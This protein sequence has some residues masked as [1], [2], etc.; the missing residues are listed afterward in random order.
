M[1]PYFTFLGQTYQLFA[2]LGLLALFVASGVAY[3]RAHKMGLSYFDM[4]MGIIFLGVGL[5]IGGSIL[6]ALV[7]I[8]VVWSNQ[9]YLF[10][11]PFLFL[12]LAFGGLIFYGGLI[13]ALIAMPLYAKYLKV[14]LSTL[15]VFIIPVFPLAHSIMR[16]GCFMAG[17]CYGI[18]HDRL[19]IAFTRSLSAPNG[20]N[21]LPVQLFETIANIFIFT[22][23]YQYTKRPRKPLYILCFYGLSYASIRF[24]LEFV[25]G[26]NV[27]GF[28]F[29]FSTSPFISVFVV[30]ICISALIY[31]KVLV[32]QE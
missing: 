30:I 5:A 21:L 20:I 17:C 29:L 6:H 32:Q 4:L 13:G 11:A 10:D 31:D 1:F 24:V 14:D 9:I 26:D 2:L 3:I 25:R 22:A 28:I 23:L 18:E 12:R 15:I 27:R 19:G 16:I 7:N 8:P